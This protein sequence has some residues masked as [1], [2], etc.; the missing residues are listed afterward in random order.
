[1]QP[2]GQVYFENREKEKFESKKEQQKEAK[3]T[4]RFW[5]EVLKDVLI[6]IF[7]LIIE[8]KFGLVREIIRTFF[9]WG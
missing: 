8:G 1:V 6:F 4:R 3:E 9:A 7:G 5:V 2:K